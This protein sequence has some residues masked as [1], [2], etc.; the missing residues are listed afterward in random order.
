MSWRSLAR[1]FTI[2][3][4]AASWNAFAWA[5]TMTFEERVDC[6]AAVENVYWAHR[7]WPAENRTPKPPRELVLPRAA[8][9]RQV[10]D[11]LRYETALER[12]WGRGITPPELQAE[13]DRQARDTRDPEMLRDLRAALGND[14]YKVAEC[15]VRPEMTERRLRQWY[16]GD[17]GLHADT[18]ERAERELAAGASLAA[19][20]TGSGTVETLEWVKDDGSASAPR[21][22]GVVTL[23]A[24]E[25]AEATAD[26]ASAFGVA[27]PALPVAAERGPVG[28]RLLARLPLG[29]PSALQEDADRFFTRVITSRAPGRVRVATVAWPK[30]S[31]AAWWSIVRGELAPAEPPAASYVIGPITAGGCT[32]DTWETSSG[33]QGPP[34]ARQYHGAVWTGSEMI[35]WG[36]AGANGNIA[37]GARYSP[38]TDTWTPLSL[39]GAPSAR[40]L[41]RMVW[42][43]TQMVVWGGYSGAYL[44][45]GGRYSPNTDT[46]TATSTTGAPSG[47]YLHTAVWTGT[48]MIVWGGNVN[49]STSL[50][51]GGRYDP[52]T[53]TWTP[54]T[55]TNAP[56]ARYGHVA[57]WTG[58]RM[59]VWGGVAGVGNYPASGGRYDPATDTWTATNTVNA[60]AGRANAAA[61]WTGDRMLVWGGTAGF[62]VGSGG[63]YVPDTDTW[64]AISN[65]QAPVGRN[66]HTAVWTG[67]EMLVWGG[68]SGGAPVNNGGRY[69][70]LTDTWKTIDTGSAPAARYGH[71]A[72]WTG[73]EMVVWGG[74]G[75]RQLDSGGRYSP[76][77]NS[78]TPTSTGAGP[79]ARNVHSAVWTG[80]EMIV[81]GGNVQ[82]TNTGGR[83]VPATDSWVPTDTATAPAA[84]SG[85][86]AVWTGTE[87]IVWGGYNAGYLNTG[88]RYSPA[89]DTWVATDT[90]T[91]PAGRWAHSGVWT[92]AELIV[93]G[94]MT[95]ASRTRTGGRYDPATDHWVATNDVTA[96]EARWG[97]TAVWTGSQMIVWGGVGTSVLNSGGRYD[98][99]TDT[100]TATSL[101]SA[102]APRQYHGAA[103]TGAAM[104]VWG[105]RGAATALDSGARY[106]PLAD[107]WSATSAFGAP[108]P[109][110]QHSG[111]WTGSNLVIWGGSDATGVR[112]SSGGRY[113]PS[114][115]S[116][117]PITA[118]GAPSARQLHSAVWTGSRMIVWGGDDG[119]TLASGASYCSDLP[120]A[121]AITS[122]ASVTFHVGRPR[123]FTVTTTGFPWPAVQ[124]LGALPTGVSFVDNGDGT[125]TLVGTAAVSTDGSYPLQ[126]T[127]SSGFGADAQQF[128]TLIVDSSPEFTSASKAS[129]VLGG[130]GSFTVTT[131][132]NPL[133]S[134]SVTGALPAGVTLTDHHDGTAVL[135]GKPGPGTVGTY[136]VTLSAANGVGSPATQSFALVV[137][138]DSFFTVAPCRVFDSRLAENGPA[139][140]TGTAR[141][142]QIGGVCGVS[143]SAKAAALNI[144]VVNPSGTGEIAVVPGNIGIVSTSSASFSA[145]KTRANNTLIGLAGTGQVGSVAAMLNIPANGSAHLVIDVTGYVE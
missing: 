130:Q 42:T 24:A 4:L 97:A 136:V 70:P 96:P 53:D 57:L 123:R 41:P 75:G 73:S 118:F 105:G 5:R 59:V 103:W 86:S 87:M 65:A 7:V 38:S 49:G 67:A 85:H 101:V 47:R 74:Y 83:Y 143:S 110:Y 142:I 54:T 12:V 111:V 135:S 112:L 9:A 94:G 22:A 133:A 144:T 108:A 60:P 19:L 109:R 64:S 33:L 13:L 63:V 27:A 16:A 107:A 68:T 31:F 76:L 34:S 114:S 26:L 29:T 93:W 137:T 122:A 124:A 104:I 20:R 3:A 145:A 61:V 106:D 10:A 120:E 131:V 43:G 72:V 82:P 117:Q 98:P 51:T 28:R 18:R 128:F 141:L 134:I 45:T 8:I 129:F 48:Q 95:S 15:L 25:W 132:G 113:V 115:N 2:A 39:V 138:G 140:V 81:W 121:P 17:R 52:V 80:T 1:Y 91:A 90:A 40:Q 127:A 100:W 37:T 89:T 102:P 139:L 88:G 23:P 55:Q 46:W 84:R 58:T 69:S 62:D 30:R 11:S 79:T 71:T 14:P 77:A 35:V 92:G 32:D 119:G 116:W 56:V 126:L 78:W 21:P 44:N 66:A 50:D 125:A 99:S 36:G 6:R